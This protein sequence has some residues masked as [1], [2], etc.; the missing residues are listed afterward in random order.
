MQTEIQVATPFEIKGNP[1]V[2]LYLSGIERVIGD[3]AE[4]GIEDDGI[5]HYL[6]LTMVID[7][8]FALIRG[9]KTASDDDDRDFFMLF[10]VSIDDE[11]LASESFE[12]DSIRV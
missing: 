2:L 6:E 9:V 1:H 12:D 3:V 8:L 11:L 4:E 10:S 7:S 5:Y